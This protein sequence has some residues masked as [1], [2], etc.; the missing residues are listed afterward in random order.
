MLTMI[1]KPPIETWI[2]KLNNKIIK[3]KN[4]N[5]YEVTYFITSDNVKKSLWPVKWTKGKP[6]CGP[7]FVVSNITVQM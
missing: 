7:A 1:F 4:G 6:K 5:T 3:K 2:I